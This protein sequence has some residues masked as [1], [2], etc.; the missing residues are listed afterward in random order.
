MNK[1]YNSFIKFSKKNFRRNLSWLDRDEDSPTFGSFDRNFWHYKITD[2]NSDI[3]QQG[4]YTLIGLYKK[5]FPFNNFQFDSLSFMQ[6]YH[7]LGVQRS[8]KILG[9][10][11]RLAILETNQNYLVHKYFF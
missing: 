7:I 2:F 11:A 9:I 10:F 5:D 6:Q 1:I 8:I 3:L 4:I